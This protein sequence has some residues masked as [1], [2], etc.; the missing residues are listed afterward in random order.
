M[1]PAARIVGFTLLS[2][3][4]FTQGQNYASCNLR[5]RQTEQRITDGFKKRIS[6]CHQGCGVARSG[7]SETI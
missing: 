5:L 2:G 3:S 1:V 6:C 7:T 4:S